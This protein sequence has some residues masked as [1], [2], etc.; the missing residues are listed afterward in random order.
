MKNVTKI[1]LTLVCWFNICVI[2]ETITGKVV[3]V[4]DGDTITVLDDSNQIKVR[5]EGIDTPEAKQPFGTKAK[6]ALSEMVFGKDVTLEWNEKDRYGRTLGHI[7]INGKWVNLEMV[8]QG[9]AWHYKQYSKDQ[10]L[11]EAEIAARKAKLGLWSDPKPV[12]PWDWRKGVRSEASTATKKSESADKAAPAFVY[13]T[14]TG[15]KYHVE[16][17]R[18]LKDSKHK[19]TFADAKGRGLTACKV[20]GGQ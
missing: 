16:G 9:M 11:A 10:Q 19:V 15:K 14:D 20:C 1:I 2:S 18:Y 5:L 12:A 6:Q 7:H 3:S 4:Y 17:C 13:I 8:K